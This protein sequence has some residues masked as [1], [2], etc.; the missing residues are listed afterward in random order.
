VVATVS[1]IFLGGN[2]EGVDRVAVPWIRPTMGRGARIRHAQ[3][4]IRN[5]RCGSS[6]TLT[7]YT[8]F[9][10]QN[11]KITAKHSASQFLYFNSIFSC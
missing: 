6:G 10:L 3:G 2:R 9:N 7:R 1:A 11:V 4:C 5:R 8:S